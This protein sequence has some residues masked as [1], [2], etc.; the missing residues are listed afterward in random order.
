[1]NMG[2][3]DFAA[4]GSGIGQ[5]VHVLP[6]QAERLACPEASVAQQHNHETVAGPVAG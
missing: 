5:E 6:A 2:T 1:M 4:K 3:D